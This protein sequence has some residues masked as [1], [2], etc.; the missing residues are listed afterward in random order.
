MSASLL[1]ALFLGITCSAS[2]QIDGDAP[3][4]GAAQHVGTSCDTFARVAKDF[5]N[6]RGLKVAQSYTKTDE[7]W[8]CGPGYRCVMFGGA[9]PRTANG[10][11]LTRDDVVRNYLTDPSKVDFRSKNLTRGY[12]AVPDRNFRMGAS[13][14]LKTEGSGCFAKLFMTLGMGGTVFL[15]ILPSDLYTWPIPPDNGRLQT[16]YMAAIITKL[17]R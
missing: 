11:S 12:R 13:L 5:L 3:D 16:E 1:A 6:G 8:A 4:K 7:D 10:E 15:G 17:P 9:S 14:Q 2:A